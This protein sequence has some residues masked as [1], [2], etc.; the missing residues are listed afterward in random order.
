MLTF[1]QFSGFLKSEN[2]KTATAMM[3]Q[4]KDDI[5][6]T[7]SSQVRQAQDA[8]Q[9]SNAG[10]ALAAFVPFSFCTSVCYILSMI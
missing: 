7:H 6:S 10:L 1:R 3:K 4:I 2:V 8:G 9:I 5:K